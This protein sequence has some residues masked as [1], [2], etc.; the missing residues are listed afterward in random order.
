MRGNGRGNQYV[1]VK[2]EVPKNLTSRQ[3]EILKEFEDE[4]NYKQKKSFK[5]KMKDLF[6]IE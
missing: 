3:K 1:T 6:D 2:V 5:Q 4:K